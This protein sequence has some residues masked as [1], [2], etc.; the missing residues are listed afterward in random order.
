MLIQHRRIKRIFWAK[1]EVP[2]ATVIVVEGQKYVLLR[3]DCS[4]SIG[5]IQATLSLATWKHIQCRL[6]LAW[7]CWRWIKLN[8][9]A[10]RPTALFLVGGCSNQRASRDITNIPADAL[11]DSCSQKC[12]AE[13]PNMFNVDLARDH[14]TKG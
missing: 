9:K 2:T 6:I 7:M 12:V 1:A 10:D 3:A 14:R 4:L 5:T 8:R 11:L 13:H